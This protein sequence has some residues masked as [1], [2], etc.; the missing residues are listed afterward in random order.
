M[1]PV[2]PTTF[3]QALE[4]ACLQAR[5][6]Y[7]LQQSE[8]TLHMTLAKLKGIL[9][10]CMVC[11]RSMGGTSAAQEMMEIAREIVERHQRELVREG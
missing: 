4:R 5:S 1:H 7:R 9:T 6:E 3:R 2:D 11:A 10:G 8:E